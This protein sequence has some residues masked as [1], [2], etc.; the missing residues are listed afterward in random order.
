MEA[1]AARSKGSVPEASLS[2]P[3][4]A[5]PSAIDFFDSDMDDKQSPGSESSPS[6][7]PTSPQPPPPPPPLPPPSSSPPPAP[8]P[9]PS[10][11]PAR[12]SD[13]KVQFRIPTQPS[14][15]FPFPPFPRFR[16]AELLAI[17]RCLKS[18]PGVLS[19]QKNNMSFRLGR[20]MLFHASKTRTF[21]VMSDP[22]LL[23]AS[24][25]DRLVPLRGLPVRSAAT[26][27]I[28][29][30][31]VSGA[32]VIASLFLLIGVES[33]G[34]AITSRNQKRGPRRPVP[35]AD[36][37]TVP[38]P[39][40]RTRRLRGSGALLR[41]LQ[42]AELHRAAGLRRAAAAL[43]EHS[44]PRDRLRLNHYCLQQ[45]DHR[46]CDGSSSSSH[47]QHHRGRPSTKPQATRCKG[48]SA[49]SP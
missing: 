33:E 21:I 47:R 11:L 20:L 29:T 8:S 1:M 25:I 2:R 22:P 10:P 41:P 14:N 32:I 48:S 38:M 42:A 27:A 3:R 28:P 18:S 26:I 31:G 12:P 36:T 4:T 30:T 39:A 43:L 46:C 5:R 44:R 49:A 23:R 37:D 40:E 34:R 19:L 45:I 15:Y 13:E 7:L 24:A 17:K 35:P 6:T 9:L 16:Y